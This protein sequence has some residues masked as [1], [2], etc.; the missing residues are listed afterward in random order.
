MSEKSVRHL[1][2]QHCLAVEDFHECFY[3]VLAIRNHIRS[4]SLLIPVRRCHYCYTQSLYSQL[5]E[6]VALTARMSGSS[7]ISN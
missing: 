6:K 3:E 5:D 4:I 1:S 7:A 2:T